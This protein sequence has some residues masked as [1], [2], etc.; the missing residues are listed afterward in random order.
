MAASAVQAAM[1]EVRQNADLPDRQRILSLLE[2][3][4]SKLADLQQVVAANL[5]GA[6]AIHERNQTTLQPHDTTLAALAGTEMVPSLRELTAPPYTVK[7]VFDKVRASATKLADE[8]RLAHPPRTDEARRWDTVASTVGRHT[9]D[10]DPAKKGTVESQYRAGQLV[11][12]VAREPL[13]LSARQ[14]SANVSSL[15]RLAATVARLYTTEAPPLA[16]PTAYQSTNSSSASAKDVFDVMVSTLRYDHV[17]AVARYGSEHAIV[18]QV[19]AAVDLAHA[20]RSGMVHVRPASTY[21]R[22]SYP[23]TV[24]QQDPTAGVWNNMLRQHAARHIP[25]A[26]VFQSLTDEAIVR[27]TIDKQF[28]QRVN[29]VRVAGAGR[30]NYVLAKDDVG[31]WYVK[32]Y[33]AD[34]QDIIRSARNLALFSAGPALGANLLGGRQPQA[35]GLAGLDAGAVPGAPQAVTPPTTTA[36]RSTLGRQLDR[37]ARRYREQTIEARKALQNDIQGLDAAVRAA[38][39]EVIAAPEVTKLDT[40]KAFPSTNSSAVTALGVQRTD[41]ADKPLTTLNREIATALREVQRYRTALTA[42]IV[43]HTAAGA[44]E[45]T[46]ISSDDGPKARAAADRVVRDLLDRH[47]RERQTSAAQYESGLI[48]IGETAGL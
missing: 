17:A 44:A 30:T 37:I 46:K 4:A 3:G 47:V 20:Y 33:S 38:I 35:S 1:A 40:A 11:L 29:Q 32:N 28:W 5:E 45:T 2:G 22:D 34:A 12:L 26:D 31:N 25:F 13:E 15:Q 6:R 36:G 42:A 14:S 27:R 18:K 48:L 10:A 7:E 24:L 8:S 21:L 39:A 9:F 19:E 16:V 43:K 23:A 41:N